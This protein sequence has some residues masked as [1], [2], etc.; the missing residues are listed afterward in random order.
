MSM[1]I[2]PSLGV[3]RDTGG[4]NPV[5]ALG[6]D[7]LAYWEADRADTIT[8]TGGLVSSWRD[9]IGGLNVGQGGGANKPVYDPTIFNGRP[10]VTFDGVDDALEGTIGSSALPN[11]ANPCEMWCLADQQEPGVD[12]NTVNRVAFMYGNG[13]F[14]FDRRLRKRNLDGVQQSHLIVGTGASSA[15]V[16]NTSVVLLGRHVMRARITPTSI[17]YIVDSSAEVTRTS[18]VTSTTV[19]KVGIGC[20]GVVGGQIWK[21]SIAACLV[22]LPLSAQKAADLMNFLN[23]RR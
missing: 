13:N 23:S 20:I 18:T 4:Y 8:A 12:A 1:W 6:T 21:G 14:L 2:G 10:A 11:A 15:Q 19:S 16:D 22:T 3:T 5:S 17:H 9:I 7:L